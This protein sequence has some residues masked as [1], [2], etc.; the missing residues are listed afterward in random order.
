MQILTL[1]PTVRRLTI[2]AFR[3]G[4]DVP[5]PQPQEKEG[6]DSFDGEE[7]G[8]D[9]FSEVENDLEQAGMLPLDAVAIRGLY[10]GERFAEPVFASDSVLADLAALAPQSPLHVPRLV[11]LVE[12]VRRKFPETPVVL[13]FETA[14]FV[15]LP[16][17]ER[18]YGLDP[19]LARSHSLRRFGFHGVFH[20][21]ACLEAVRTMGSPQARL[22]SICLEPRPELAACRG[23]R[24]VMVTGG[25]TPIEGLPGE[26]SCGDLDP[27]VT[28]KLA[29]ADGLGPEGASRLLTGESGFRG[30]A[31]RN[32]TLAEV[33]E[34]TDD[35]LQL[36]REVFL[37]ALLRA[38]GAGVAALGGLDAVVYSGR[39][40]SSA[41]L[42]HLWLNGRLNQTLGCN[43][44]C[45]IHEHTLPQHL[46]N[47][48]Y[49]MVRENDAAAAPV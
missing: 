21:A 13:A 37:H 7:N 25:S 49:V 46:C 14:F 24:P 8:A 17:R 15:P 38:A 33:L 45:L 3:N 2:H 27:S 47:I 39:Y 48:A 36:A 1:Q 26:T 29:D 44:S 42:L 20:E 40:A 12:A 11:Q 35:D 5:L 34:S 31:G 19:E 32:V 16:E 10:G 43:T 6:H 28:L 9:L 22:L 23:R 4:T 41:S 18:H 30:L